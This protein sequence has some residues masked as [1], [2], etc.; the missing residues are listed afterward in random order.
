[1]VFAVTRSGR[2][3]RKGIFGTVNS[4]LE[5]VLVPPGL[6]TKN[7]KSFLSSVPL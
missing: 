6:A 5:P 1:M 4:F 3:Q 2:A 7:C